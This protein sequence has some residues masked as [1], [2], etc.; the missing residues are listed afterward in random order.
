[1]FD[2]ERF[3]E[4]CRLYEQANA[5]DPAALIGSA[6]GQ[7]AYCRLA[8]AVERLPA[9]PP[10]RL[11]ELEEE[12]RQAIAL[13]GDKPQLQTYGQTVLDRVKATRGNAATPATTGDWAVFESTNFRILSRSP[14]DVA[15]RFAAA[16]EK[17]RAAAFEKWFGPTNQTWSPRC[18]VYLY[19]AA[20]EYVR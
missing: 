17:A 4:A 16:A 20:D 14:R 6:R 5:K 9:T 7:W 8:V 3:A 11:P 13:A 1:A 12:V 18:E 2:Q 15:E 19:P 10:D